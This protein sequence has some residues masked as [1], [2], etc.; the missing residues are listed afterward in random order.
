VAKT[1]EYERKVRRTVAN[2]QRHEVE[3]RAALDYLARI[4]E[5]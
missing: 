5:H 2:I 4:G 3:D 1:P